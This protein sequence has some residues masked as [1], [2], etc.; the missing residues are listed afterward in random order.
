MIK[1]HANDRTEIKTAIVGD[2]I[3]SIGLKDTTTG[4]TLWIEMASYPESV[5]YKENA[6]G[7]FGQYEIEVAKISANTGVPMYL[8]VYGGY[9]LDRDE[10]PSCK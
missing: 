9:S 10:W 8:F 1:V 5:G 7:S 6:G 3:A 4:K 2:I